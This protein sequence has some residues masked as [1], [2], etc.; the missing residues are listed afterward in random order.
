MKD[1]CHIFVQVK[2]CKNADKH[3]RCSLKPNKNGFITCSK[4]KVLFLKEDNVPNPL[5]KS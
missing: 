4:E 2:T 5:L 3:G 1:K